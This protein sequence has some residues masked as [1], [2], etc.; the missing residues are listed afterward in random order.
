MGTVDDPGL[1]APISSA[2]RLP[3]EILGLIMCKIRDHAVLQACC[4]ASSCLLPYARKA[5]WTDVY[6]SM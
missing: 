3:V 1:E 5:L 4:L 6:I 2:P